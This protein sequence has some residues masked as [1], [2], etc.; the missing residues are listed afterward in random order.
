MYFI[1]KFYILS[2]KA[3]IPAFRP[4]HRARDTAP[5]LVLPLTNTLVLV[6]IDM[7]QSA[8]LRCG[9]D[10]YMFTASVCW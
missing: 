3:R 9:V 4:M 5:S 8:A 2:G 1:L 10:F 6:L 7:S